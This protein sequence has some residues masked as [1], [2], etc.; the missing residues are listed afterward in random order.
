MGK[1]TTPVRAAGGCLCG[2]VRY[3]VRGPLRPV[4]AC[5]CSQCR[6]TTGHF[7]ASTAAKREHVALRRETGLAWYA[8]SEA[9]RRGFCRHCGSTLFWDGRGRDT[10]SI[11]A[12]TLDAPT[13]LKLVQHIFT[14]DKSDYYTIDDG[15]PRSTGGAFKVAVP[16]S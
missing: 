4:V 16:P 2:E 5:H 11:A 14:A 8:S 10:I 7:L 9:A 13:G 12:G 15:L 3:E 6:R 1:E